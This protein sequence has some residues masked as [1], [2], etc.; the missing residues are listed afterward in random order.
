VA[1]TLQNALVHGPRTQRLVVIFRLVGTRP[2]AIIAHHI[3]VESLDY[4]FRTV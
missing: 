2:P 3:Q 4:H 1:R